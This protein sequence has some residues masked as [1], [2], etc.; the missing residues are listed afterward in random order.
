MSL[1]NH[2][3]ASSKVMRRLLFAV[4]SIIPACLYGQNTITGLV[5]DSET[6][7][8]L[9]FATVYING[10]TKGTTTDNDGRFEL[11]N[12]SFPTTV[13]FSFVGYKPQA[14]NL[15]RVP[16]KMTISLEANNDLP[17]VVISGKAKRR[18]LNYFKRMFLGDDY[19]GR[20]AVIKNEQVIMIDNSESTKPVFVTTDTHQVVEDSDGGRVT[21]AD[22]VK[23]FFNAWAYEPIVIDMPL[24]GYELYVDLVQ[25]TV[26]KTNSRIYTQGGPLE[27]NNRTQCDMLGYFYFKPYENLKKR[28]AEKIEENRRQA[29]YNS[30]QHFLRSFYEDRLE[31]NGYTLS[32]TKYAAGVVDGD[33]VIKPLTF[34]VDIKKYSAF[35]GDN[36]MQIYGLNGSP[37]NIR[38]YH[39]RDGSPLNLKE[40][41][42]AVY[43]EEEEKNPFGPS[44]KIEYNTFSKSGITFRED[45]CTFLKEGVVFDNNILF[46]GT[47]AE[48]KIGACLPDDYTPVVVNERENR[49]ETVKYDLA[50]NDTSSYTEEL[51]KF[52]GNI[53][54]FN[55]L[56]PQE[57]VYLE[58]D[59]T[60]YF[61]G[62]NIWYKAF[63]TH[64]TTLERA[65]SGV[66][67][68]DFL[69]PTGQLLRQQKLEIV[70]GQANGSISLLDEGTAQSREKRGVMAY[71]SGFYEIRAYTQNMLDFSPEAIFS[72][73]IPVYT[74]PKYV[75]E[76]DKSHVVSYQDNPLIENVRDKTDVQKRQ[77]N[78][79]NVTFYPEGG[80]LVNGLPCK[81][82]F[83]ATGDDAFGIKGALVVPGLDDS[84]LTVHDGMGSFIITPKGTG[85]VQFIT[86]DGKSSRFSLPRPVRSGYSMIANPYSDSLLQVNIWR[87]LDR[88]GEPVALTVTC[89]GDIIYFEEI[90]DSIDSSL[91]IDCSSWPIGVC[92]MTLYDRNGMIL[93]SRSI[94]HNND[95]FRS[96]TIIANT[97]SMSRQAF[98]KEVLEFKLNDKDGNPLR[99]R[100]CLSVRDAE[101]YGGGQTDN[102][103][104]NL[105]L[106]SDL[107]GY[108]HDPAWYLESND[109]EHREASNL[110]TLV[111]GWERYEWQY[112]TGLK[113]FEEKHRIE[114]GLTMNGWILS[115]RKRE[116]VADIG[117]YAVLVPD[118]SK[119]LHW[120]ID[121]FEHHTDSTGYFGFDLSDFYGEGKFSFN[122]MST[123]R[124][125]Q[126]K[127]ERNKRIKLERADRPSP[128][129]FLKQEMELNHNKSHKAGNNFNSPDDD[130]PLIISTDQG[131]VLDAVDIEAEA[132]KRQFI[133]YD[134]FTSFDAEED[135]EMELDMGEYTTN[136]EG[137]FLDRGIRFGDAYVEETNGNDTYIEKGI[138]PFFYVHN[139]K[140][141][142]D[143]KPFD[144]PMQIDMI[145][146]KSILVYD[147]PMTLRQLTQLTP[148]LNDYHRKHIDTEWFQEVETS[149]D[150]YYLIDI[151]IKEDKNLLFYGEIR[152][153]GRRFTKVKGYTKPVQF[154]SPKYPEGPISG[155][156]DARRTLYWNPNVITDEEG[157][158][159]VEFYNNSFTRKFTI[160]AAGI[161]ASGIPY[162]LNQDW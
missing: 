81:V 1:T 91:N 86:P 144:N 119:K 7:E 89:R 141:L 12:V 157:R 5:V 116:P 58:F 41:K 37:L 72:R 73:V 35:L 112:M 128:R 48:K 33:T 61:Q 42:E 104:T 23:S 40:N 146:V 6:R 154:Y 143:K 152:D 115:N 110:L 124:N 10:T 4:L 93:S 147:Q 76:Y 27:I 13:V 109:E 132:G 20:N 82:A 106:S 46:G 16:N 52:A 55:E 77:N 15:D 62:E 102:L 134:T 69:A 83:K 43:L 145:D 75:G 78:N 100:F 11:K 22:E 19:W 85:T 60:A 125:G 117:I 84:V 122:L 2:Q 64:A 56:F 53:R 158:A 9:P 3:I 28:Q 129:S 71:P 111:Q 90:K 123:K 34:P 99:D 8:P 38:Y 88:K 162:I 70:A 63:V 18:D 79:V 140:K 44:T 161:T 113:D 47:I 14:H 159:R 130:Q 57:K 97:D 66:L 54:Q 131:I 136:V 101:D 92:R 25:F 138:K 24:L 87:T 118:E 121:K 30:S 114:E 21:K 108:I 29:Y 120:T 49:K 39:Q 96:P 31:E 26:E 94:F 45:T 149:W 133:D 67:Y 156:I 127:Y 148:L 74:Q 135:T 50:V 95:E 32:M 36:M 126:S 107:R 68:V 51:M 142:L 151:Q 160:N 80:D 105:L 155:D 59:N 65:P 153:M 150:R 17:E 98:G 137:Y 103:Q 139:Q